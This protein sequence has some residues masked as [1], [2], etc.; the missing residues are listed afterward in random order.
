MGENTQTTNA[1][2]KHIHYTHINVYKYINIYIYTHTTTTTT[3]TTTTNNNNNDNNDDN[4]DILY[5]YHYCTY[6]GHSLTVAE[7]GAENPQDAG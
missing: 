2:I 6:E 5:Y 3:T 7:R 4:S 1:H